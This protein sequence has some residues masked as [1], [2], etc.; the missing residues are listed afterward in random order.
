M[1]WN[2]PK[3][4]V[5]KIPMPEVKQPQKIYI[6]QTNVSLDEN[7]VSQD[8]QSRMFGYGESWD[9][10]KKYLLS[11]EPDTEKLVRGTMIGTIKPSNSKIEEILINDD[12]HLEV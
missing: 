9:E 1:S 5:P 3:P 2:C 6:I 10:F 7:G 11:N 8:F 12:F 4:N